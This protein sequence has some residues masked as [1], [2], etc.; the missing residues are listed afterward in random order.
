LNHFFPDR[1]KAAA[2]VGQF[3]EPTTIGCPS[4]QVR[5]AVTAV[6]PD[7]GGKGDRHLQTGEFAQQQGGCLVIYERKRNENFLQ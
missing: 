2:E 7:T 4:V 3:R 1:P 5:G 6:H